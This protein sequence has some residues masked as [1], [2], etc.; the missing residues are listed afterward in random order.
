[1]L[2]GIGHPRCGT[3]FTA[4]L[5]RS[6]G[7][8][9]EHEKIGKEGIVSW[10]ALSGRESVPWGH[11]IGPLT[12]EFRLFCVARSPL[13]AIGSILPENNN[14]RSIGWRAMVIWEKLGIDIF[15]RSEVPQTGLGLAFASYAYWYRMALD[16]RPGIIFRVDRQEDDA[17]LAAFVG[18]PL[19]RGSGIETNSRPHIR[20]DD[21][22]IEELSDFPR[23]LL[24]TA[25]DVADALGYPEDAGVI[26]AR[27]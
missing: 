12:E 18:Q 2:V 23:P 26:S 20:R 21:W 9:V 4:A 14:R 5:L 27:M 19:Q 1:M 22:R 7:V 3:G 10:M 15:S 8:Q 24:Y 17:G 13:A 16:L 25:I 11:A 6:G